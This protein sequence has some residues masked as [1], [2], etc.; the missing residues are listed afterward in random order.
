MPKRRKEISPNV[1]QAS[2]IGQMALPKARLLHYNLL[3]GIL[4]AGTPKGLDYCAH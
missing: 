3:V 1:K 2:V 4:N